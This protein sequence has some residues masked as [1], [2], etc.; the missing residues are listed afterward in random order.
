MH[1]AAWPDTVEELTRV[2][3]ELAEAKPEPWRPACAAELRVGGAFV[4]FERGRVGPGA[5][6]DHAWA[7]AAVTQGQLLRAET[8]LEGSAGA[9]FLS[10]W[11]ALREGPLLADVVRRLALLPEVLLVDATGRDHPR[12]AG[13]ALQLGQVLDLPTIGVTRRPLIA[14]GGL[15]GAS[16]GCKAPLELD[17]ELVGYV[18]RPTPSSQPIIVHAAWRTSPEVAAEVVMACLGGR[19]TPEPLRRARQAAREARTESQLGAAH[20]DRTSARP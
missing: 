19:R 1:I 17:A 2:Q 18:L 9:P 6:G 14:L 13:L 7:G 15:P 4:C 5:H 10:G 20:P 16:A 3:L 8:V 12:R 11:L